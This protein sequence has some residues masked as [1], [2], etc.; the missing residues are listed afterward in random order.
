MYIRF[1]TGEIDED[2]GREAGV[3]GIAHELRDSAQVTDSDRAKLHELLKWFAAN[4]EE[5]SRFTTAKPPHYR[6]QARAIS[7]FKDTAKDPIAR[8]REMIAILDR[9]DIH[10]E[11]IQTDRPGY[12]VYE[13][14]HQIVAEPFSDADF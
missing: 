13:D 11:M 10:I 9:H 2:S 6:K 1:I 14:V 4:L 5:P 8:L 3:F 7:W 12:V